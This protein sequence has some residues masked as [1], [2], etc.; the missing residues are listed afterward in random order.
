VAGVL[1]KAVYY[2][3]QPTSVPAGGPWEN[4]LRRPPALDEAPAFADIPTAGQSVAASRPVMTV[5]ADGASLDE[6]EAGLRAA[7]TTMDQWLLK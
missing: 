1:G 2:V 3:L 6:C 7:A 5:F 4:V